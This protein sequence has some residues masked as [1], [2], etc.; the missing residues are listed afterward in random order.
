MSAD[1]G[2]QSRT[3]TSDPQLSGSAR[4]LLRDCSLEM[5]ARDVASLADAV[6]QLPPRTRMHLT[7]L[8]NETLPMRLEAA[9]AVREAGLVPVPHIA[10]RRLRS[11]KDLRD[12]LEGLA[13]LGASE[14]VFLVGGDPARPEGPYEDALSLIRSGHLQE[15][16]VHAA[17]ITGYPEGHPQ[18]TNDALEQS[19][20]HKLAALA[21]AG[22]DTWITSQ[23][24]F[25]ADAVAAWIGGLRRQ[26]VTAPVRIG[27]PGP[28]GIKRLLGFARRLGISANTSLIKK[29][30]L[31]V[32]QLVGRSTPQVFVE[33]TASALGSVEHGTT[34]IHLYTFG[35]LEGSAAW[36]A[37]SAARPTAGQEDDRED[38]DR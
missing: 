25:D 13:E 22:L 20:R 14:K 6:P 10:A 7:F 1:A 34:G 32:T 21:E 31:S 9:R 15:H 37:R 29:Y 23:F 33:R 16:G 38:G 11:E 4:A 12:Y 26:G 2:A 35:G 17:G 3:V 30:G 18:I 36:L 28:A 8:E 19:Q 24:S 27:A 5:T